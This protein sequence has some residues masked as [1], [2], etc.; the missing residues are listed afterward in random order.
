MRLGF[1]STTTPSRYALR[2]LLQSESGGARDADIRLASFCFLSREDITLLI[3]ITAL[4]VAFGSLFWQ[5]YLAYRIDR[6]R[7]KASIDQV[8]MP[9]PI[10][11]KV[12]EV[13]I[14]RATNVGKRQ[15][16]TRST[17]LALG[18]PRRWFLKWM[19]KRWR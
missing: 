17:L 7:I 5:I 19:P 6:P 14:A 12:W 18:R 16:E 15:I 4:A 11:G 9:D 1:S 8:V 10:T 2:R 3:A 13:V